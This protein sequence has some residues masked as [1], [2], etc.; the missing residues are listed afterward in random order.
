MVILLRSEP[1]R[2]INLH[3]QE[4]DPVPVIMQCVS[5]RVL[6]AGGKFSFHLDLTDLVPGFSLVAF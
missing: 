3:I 1:E 5:R 6:E 4:F 2:T